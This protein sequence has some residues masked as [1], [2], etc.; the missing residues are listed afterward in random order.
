MQTDTLNLF[1]PRYTTRTDTKYLATRKRVLSSETNPWFFR[2]SVGEGVGGP[3]VGT[4][5]IWP[6]AIMMRA[7]TSTDDAE[8]IQCL[9]ILKNT[10]GGTLFMH[11][12]FDR[13]NA[14]Y[15][16]YTRQWFSW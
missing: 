3:H 4:G 10:T 12:S 1:K 14:F 15:P 6:M 13:N 5:H 11:E 9:T 2:G 8:I 7:L 16:H